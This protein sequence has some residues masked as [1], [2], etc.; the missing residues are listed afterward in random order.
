[1]QSL[2]LNDQNCP[3]CLYSYCC[4][5][6]ETWGTIVDKLKTLMYALLHHIHPCYLEKNSLWKF[7]VLCT[8]SEKAE[9]FH[10]KSPGKEYWSNPGAQWVSWAVSVSLRAAISSLTLHFNSLCC[11]IFKNGIWCL[12]IQV[13]WGPRSMAWVVRPLHQWTWVNTFF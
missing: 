6:N 7:V 3:V 12:S 1:M 13:C 10:P 11:K 5:E 9:D 8:G 2:M 4:C